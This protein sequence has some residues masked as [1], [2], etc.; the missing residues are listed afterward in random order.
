MTILLKTGYFTKFSDKPPGQ[1]VYLTESRV[2]RTVK[3]VKIPVY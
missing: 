2:S 1:R 3:T